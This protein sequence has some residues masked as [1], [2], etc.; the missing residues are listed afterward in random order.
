[1]GDVE[2]SRTRVRR[3]LNKIIEGCADAYVR[4]LANHEEVGSEEEDG[5]E[6]PSGVELTVEE[7]AQKENGRAFEMENE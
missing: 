3:V 7:D 4:K 5:E 2:P 6:E 1:M